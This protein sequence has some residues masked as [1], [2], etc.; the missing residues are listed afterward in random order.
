MPLPNATYGVYL[1]DTQP[2]ILGARYRYLLVRFK[3]NH[4]IDQVI[5][6]NEVEVTP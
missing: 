4:E 3:D 1:V 2:V 6:T 5:P